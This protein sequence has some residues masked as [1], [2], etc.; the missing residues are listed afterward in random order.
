MSGF[1]D[2]LMRGNLIDLA[3]AVIIGTAFSAVVTTFTQVI[4]DVIGL[5]GGNP[6]FSSAHLGP[7]LIGP[8][9]NAVVAFVI[10]AAI[11]YFGILKPIE[12][13]KNLRKPAEP[14]VEVAAPTTE[15]LLTEIRDL[16]RAQQRS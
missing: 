14:P 7:I 10:V 15:D 2:F 13:L 11:V 16:L 8:F 9:I 5:V 1:R 3:V 12:V 6:D 4:L